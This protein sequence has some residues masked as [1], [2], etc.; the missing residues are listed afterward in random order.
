M[1][2]ARWFNRDQ[3]LPD[4]AMISGLLASANDLAKLGQML[5]QRG[6]FA[7]HSVL[8]EDY[9]LDDMLSPGSKEN[10]AWGWLWWINNQSHFILPDSLN[11][12]TGV[13]VPAA[14]S[15]LYSTR[16]GKGS[17]LSVVPSLNMAVAV[18]ATHAV[19]MRQALVF[20]NEIWRRLLAARASL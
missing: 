9:Y 16:D 14:P 12:V 15:D 4:G 17:F 1:T 20:E 6:Q 7:E 11:T 19:G 3:A 10:P 2:E 5:L 8:S 13:P 18:T